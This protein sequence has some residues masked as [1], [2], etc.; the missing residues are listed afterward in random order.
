MADIDRPL[1]ARGQVDAGAVGSLLSARS[2]DCDLVLC[3]PALRTRETW[4]YARRAG[5]KARQVDYPGTIYEAAASELSV[6]VRATPAGVR[7]LMVV[8]HGP[9]LPQLAYWLGSGT[10]TPLLHELSQGYPTSGLARFSVA[11][12]WAD[13]NPAG[14]RLEAFEVPR[15]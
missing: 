13:L 2:L 3:S 14:C 12:D 6:L 10:R 8:G 9:G 15:G 4:D 11:G 1:S 5:A 7:T